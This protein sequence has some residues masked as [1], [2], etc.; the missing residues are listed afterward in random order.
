M[1]FIYVSLGII[2]LAMMLLIWQIGKLSKENK[3]LAQEIKITTQKTQSQEQNLKQTLGIMQ[4][5]AKKM[6]VQQE[7]LD[8]TSHR[9]TEVEFQNAEL[10]KILQRNIQP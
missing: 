10:I 5:L 8:N 2:Y 9:L 1:F 3:V 7:V 4:E 6:H